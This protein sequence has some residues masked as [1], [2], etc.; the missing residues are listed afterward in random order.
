MKST[1]PSLFCRFVAVVV[2]TVF[3]VSS[4]GIPQLAQA[5]L[6]T[7]QIQRYRTVQYMTWP[8]ALAIAE[9]VW[10][11]KEKKNWNDFAGRVQKH[12]ERMDIAN[13]G[14]ARS[15]YD[16]IITV[17]DAKGS[18]EVTIATE[19]EG[20]DVYYSIDESIPDNF[21]PKYTAPVIIPKDAAHLKVITYQ[22]GKKAG[23]LINLSIDDLRRRQRSE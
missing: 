20:L 11:P 15:I 5:N 6:W 7:E 18:P 22:N 21:F 4:G 14:Y 23:Q 16:P 1:K 12:F 10:S 17:K 3:A 2:A 19:I 8:R 13:M 9:C